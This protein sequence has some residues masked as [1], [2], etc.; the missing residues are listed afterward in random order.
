MDEPWDS[1]HNRALI[2]RMPAVFE[3]PFAEV[4]P[5]FTTYLGVSGA[6]GILVRPVPADIRG[7]KLG[8]VR[9]GTSKTALVVDV[10]DN[11]AIE[12]DTTG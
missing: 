2:P 11:Q 9:D 3:S 1:D 10:A 4:D 12:W 7:T 5:G 6:D 8:D